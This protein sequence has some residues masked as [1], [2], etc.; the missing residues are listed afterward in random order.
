MTRPDVGK[1]GAYKAPADDGPKKRRIVI[2]AATE[3]FMAQGYGATSMEQIARTANVSKATLYAYFASKDA[4]FAT[5][6][7]ERTTRLLFDNA[8]FGGEVTD[9]RAALTRIGQT[10]LR[11]M[12]HEQTLAIYRVAVAESARF[13]ELGRAFFENG[14]QRGQ[15]GFIAWLE[16]QQG[17]GLV[18]APVPRVAAYQFMA[19]MRGCVFMRASLAIG[20][21]P[22]DAEI[23]ETIEAAVDT[24]M[25][26]F[27]TAAA[28]TR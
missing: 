20:A 11:F 2:D 7:A 27:G 9:L 17:R 24:W 26:A 16:R 4:L 3:L 22:T 23:D 15:G 28:A 19:L 18:H 12:L 6:V 21:A 13:P 8:I 10:F 14:P 1:A 25:A 5:M